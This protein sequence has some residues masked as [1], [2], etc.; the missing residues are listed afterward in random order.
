[1]TELQGRKRRTEIF[2]LIAVIVLISG[3]WGTR[4]VRNRRLADLRN[5][6]RPGETLA[7]IKP[8]AGAQVLMD[9]ASGQT[10]VPIAMA[11]YS[12]KLD[13]EAIKSYYSE[14]FAR[15]GFMPKALNFKPPAVGFCGSHYDAVLSCEAEQSS[16][17]HSYMIVLQWTDDAC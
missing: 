7:T 16:G 13:C 6:A 3:F 8:P 4:I 15:H 9:M 5:K 11:M 17:A 14:E 2:G 1:M 12:S 10:N